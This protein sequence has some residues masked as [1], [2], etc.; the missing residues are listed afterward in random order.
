MRDQRHPPYGWQPIG[1]RPRG[2]DQYDRAFG[3]G[4]RV[5][6]QLC[7]DFAGFS[8][9]LTRNTAGMRASLDATNPLG[10]LNVVN[11]AL[12]PRLSC[13]RIAAAH[14]SAFARE[15]QNSPASSYESPLCPKSRQVIASQRNDAMCQSRHFASRKNSGLFRRPPTT[16]IRSPR[17]RGRVA[18]ERTGGWRQLTRG[19]VSFL[20]RKHTFIVL[21]L[22]QL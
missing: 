20:W 3:R 9:T 1:T 10:R 12:D 5:F 11:E 2:F 7:Q 18:T 21:T 15:L 16:F 4:L 17:R 13:R 8:H 19:S 6:D 14:S 22:R